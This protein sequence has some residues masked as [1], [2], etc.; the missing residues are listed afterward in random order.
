MIVNEI[1][2]KS[3]FISTNGTL[4]VGHR[5]AFYSKT[6]KANGE[7]KLKIGIVMRV[8]AVLWTAFLPA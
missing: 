1:V 7:P 8:R 4:R 6:M 2:D 5:L 3:N